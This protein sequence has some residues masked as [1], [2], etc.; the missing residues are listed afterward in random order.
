[1]LGRSNLPMWVYAGAFSLTLAAIT[2]AALALDRTG[3]R[4]LGLVPTRARVGEFLFGFVLSVVLFAALALVRG[5]S[6]AAVWTF[7][8]AEAVVGA[9][10]GIII[11][12]LLFFP[13]ELLFR[14]YAFQRLVPALGAWPAI[15]ISAGLF[16][17]YH[18]VGSGMWGIG[19]F[20]T[21]AMPALGGVVLGMGGRSYQWARAADRAASRRKLGAGQCVL[22]S[23]ARGCVNGSPLDR[24]PH[25]DAAAD[26]LRARARHASAVHRRHVAC[27]DRRAVDFRKRSGIRMRD[28]QITLRDGR[29][30]AYTEIGERDWHCLVFFHGA[31][32]SRLHLAY[33]EDRFLDSRLRV[34]S[35]DRPGTAGRRLSQAGRWPTG[36]TTS[37]RSLTGLGSIVSSC[38]GIH[39]AGPMRSPVRHCSRSEYW[40]ALSSAV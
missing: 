13:E 37:R 17:V 28:L 31:P 35:P 6:V 1:M 14:G 29:A 16:G 5:A 12:F 7:A 39:P 24:Q 30:L 3:F 2:W 36:P 22:I 33:L 23:A 27:D 20:F 21:F 11:T 4:A 40:P 15:L 26:T 18:V 19:A 10:A 38:L 32:I 9:C 8:G 34:V 25:R